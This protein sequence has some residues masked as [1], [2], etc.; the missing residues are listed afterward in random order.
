[1]SGS[2]S[3]NQPTPQAPAVPDV[4]QDDEGDVRMDEPR[5]ITISETLRVALPDKYEGDRRELETFLLQVETYITFNQDKFNRRTAASSWAASY[6][7]GEAA[8]W[9]QP[10]LRDFFDNKDQP[11][12]CM[13]P[14]RIIFGS[15]EGFKTEIR[16][17][18]GVTNEKRVAEEKLYGLIQTGSA[19]KYA[20]EFRRYAG[21]TEWGDEAVM[22]HYRRGLKPNVKLE[23]ERSVKC[24]DLNSL[25]EESI[26][27]DDMLYEYQQ[28][29]RSKQF[30][31]NKGRYKPNQSRKRQS[32]YGDPME[33]DAMSSKNNLSQEE[34]NRRREKKLCFECGFPGHQAKDCRKKS[35]AGKPKKGNWKG[36]KQLKNMVGHQISMMSS[37]QV[38]NEHAILSWTA[39]YDDQCAIHKSEKDGA[40]WSP[41]KPRNRRQKK[42]S[43]QINMMSRDLTIYEKSVTE[44]RTDCKYVRWFMCHD[45]TCEKHHEEKFINNHFPEKP[46]APRTSTAFESPNVGEE[47]TVKEH[48]T[49]GVRVWTHPNRKSQHYDY[50]GTSEPRVGETYKLIYRDNKRFGWKQLETG[51]THW[52]FSRDDFEDSEPRIGQLWVMFRH[53]RTTQLWKQIGKEEN[54][55]VEQP[56][57][58]FLAE[59]QVYCVKSIEEGVRLWWNVLTTE[60]YYETLHTNQE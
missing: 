55:H 39:C 17:V 31:G 12:D 32:T 19:V 15:F 27:V 37:Q 11:T 36:K 24:D 26:R 49:W 30:Q 7:R 10:Y 48:S 6:L 14:T 13:R 23:L 5:E 46:Q 18:F 60:P 22:S 9:I 51:K 41:K 42:R 47:W 40:G 53:L 33:L 58:Q 34:K 44:E 20:T 28:D 45:N 25:I 57:R 21:T 43:H 56:V 59:G 16:R 3:N 35:Q 1:M 50:T 54:V 8:K 4:D 52:E 2:V 38:P 29:K